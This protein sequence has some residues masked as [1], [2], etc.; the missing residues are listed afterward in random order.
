MTEMHSFRGL[1]SIC[2]AKGEFAPREGHSTR[3]GYACPNCRFPIR[4]RDQASIILD[5][6]SKGRSI[7][8]PNLVASGRLD[9]VTI[10]EPALHGPFVNA[11]K[12]LPRYVRSYYWPDRPLGEADANGIRNED[13]TKLT[14]ADNSFDLVVTS[15][16]MEHV[17]DFKGAFAEV[18]R[19]LKPGGI[20]VFSIPNAWPFPDATEARVE[21]VDGVEHHIKP[22]HYHRAGDGTPCIVYTDFGADLIDT[23]DTLGRSRTQAVRRHSALDPCYMNATFVTRK[24]G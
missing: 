17:Y 6:F 8:L 20:H 2:G 21:I 12:K 15:D 19:V 4:W 1:C 13:I 3:E 11:F 9:G 24:L 7:S 22:A 14:F 5:E 18:L 10:Y 16:V 23:I